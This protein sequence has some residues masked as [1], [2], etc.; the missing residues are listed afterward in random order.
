MNITWLKFLI[1]FL[2]LIIFITIGYYRAFIYALII[3]SNNFTGLK[4]QAQVNKYTN[5]WV[6][7]GAAAEYE[8]HS[9]NSN[10]LS[11]SII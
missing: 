6:F 10:I 4:Q 3:R 7:V 1:F 9:Y 5:S 8:A 11:Q 2:I